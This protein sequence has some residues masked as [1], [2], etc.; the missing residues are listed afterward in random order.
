MKELFRQFRIA[1][2]SFVR[3]LAQVCK[4]AV[5]TYNKD[6][7]NNTKIEKCRININV[8]GPKEGKVRVG[9]QIWLENGWPTMR[10]GEVYDIVKTFRR[11]LGK[12]LFN[13]KGFDLDCYIQNVT[14]PSDDD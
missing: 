10:E 11:I 8:W 13:Q 3:S 12:D 2:E 14:I 1:Q 4:K 6:S 5:G 7:R 9:I